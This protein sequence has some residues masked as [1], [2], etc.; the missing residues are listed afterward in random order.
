ML[1]VIACAEQPR[2]ES[3]ARNTTGSTDP[4]RNKMNDLSGLS[5]HHLLPFS[6]AECT[7]LRFQR[8]REF[9]HPFLTA[10]YSLDPLHHRRRLHTRCVKFARLILRRCPLYL[11]GVVPETLALPPRHQAVNA[12]TSVNTKAFEYGL[13]CHL[14]SR[15]PDHST[16]RNHARI[17][18]PSPQPFRAS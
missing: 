1:V 2:V 10:R 6:A 18:P 9:A 16:C 17:K 11:G 8:P 4:A 14:P 15:L 12:N 13:T 3:G 5:V 7:V